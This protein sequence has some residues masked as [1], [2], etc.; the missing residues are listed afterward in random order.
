MTSPEVLVLRTSDWFRQSERQWRDVVGVLSAQADRID[1][2]WLR[3]AANQIGLADLVDAAV[4]DEG[5]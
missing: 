1:L 2:A 5:G 3:V 4:A